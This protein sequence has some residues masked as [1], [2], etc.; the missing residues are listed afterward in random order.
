MSSN[1]IDPTNNPIARYGP[2][3][4]GTII[5]MVLGVAALSRVGCANHHTPAG[6]AGYVRSKPLVGAGEFVGTQIGPTSTGWVWRQ[7]MINI[8]IRPRTYSPEM[9]IPTKD[10]L[11]VTLRAHAR[12]KPRPDQVKELVEKFGGENWYASNVEKQFIS[13][14]RDKVQRYEALSLKSYMRDIGDQVLKEMREKYKD[15][16][17]DFRSVDI[18]DIKYPEDVVASVVRKVVT[19]EDKL[20]AQ[21]QAQIASERIKIKQAEAVGD[22]KAQEVIRSTLDPMFLQFDALRAMEEL[23]GSKNTTFMIMPFAEDGQAPVIMQMGDK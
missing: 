4:A 18:G 7:S 6:H 23:A 22:S 14:V 2:A 8:D 1:G 5:V 20:R 9:T 10:A 12:I 3:V 16:P 11:Q 15:A 21:I 17:I 13:S 19:N